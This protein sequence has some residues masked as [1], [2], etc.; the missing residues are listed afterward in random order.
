MNTKIKNNT[1][2]FVVNGLPVG[3]YFLRIDNINTHKIVINK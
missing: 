2:E 3:I 1:F